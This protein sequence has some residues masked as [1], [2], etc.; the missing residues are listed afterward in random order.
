MADKRISQ[1]IERVDIANNDVLPIVASGATTTNKVTISTIQNWMQDNLDVGV[2]SVGI[3][4]GS[5]GTDVNVTGSPITTSGNIT[6]NIPTASATNRGLLSSA[7]WSTFNAKQPAGNYVTLDTTQTITAHKTFTASGGQPSITI[8]H[9]SG[10][11]H[12]LDITKAGNGEGIRVNKTSGSGNAMSVVGTLE[13]TTLVRTGGTS[14][15]FL[16]A[17]GSVDSSTYVT[18]DTSQAITATKQFTQGLSL[19]SAGGTNQ[20]TVVK[21]IGTIHEGSAGSNIFGFNNSNNIYFGKGLDNGGVIT[22]SNSAVRSYALPDASGTIALT[23]DLGNYVTIGT[24]QTITG[25]KTISNATTTYMDLNS[26]NANGASLNFQRNG[27]NMGHI[28]NSGVLGVG[29]LD[30]LEVRAGSTRALHLKTD[31]GQITLASTGAVT[32]SNLAGTGTRMVVADSNGVLSSLSN[33]VTGTLATGQVAFGTAANTVGGDNGLFWDNTNKRL[34][35]G[36]IIPI[37]RIH[38][39]GNSAE[40]TQYSAERVAS[41]IG[42]S[43]QLLS[44]T[45]IGQIPTLTSSSANIR[46][47]GDA[48]WSSTSSP[49]RVQFETT[50]VGS[51]TVTERWRITSAGILQSNGAQTI[52]TS[53]GNLTLATAAGNGNILLIPNG[54]GNVGVGNNSPDAK[55][56]VSDSANLLQMRIG[57]LTA[58]ISPLIRIQGRNTANTINR[59]ADIKLD[60]DLGIFTLMA[61]ATSGPS[62]NALNIF[63]GGNVGINT[64][65]DSGFRLD[66]NGTARVS[67]AATFSSSVTATNHFSTG[68]STFATS[69]GQVGIGTSSFAGD[70][71]LMVSMNGTTNTQAINVKDRNAAASSS[72]YMVFRKSD[73]TFQG[74]IR[75]AGTDNA[76]YVGGNEYISFGTGGNTERMRITSDAYLR[77]AAGSGGIQFNGDTSAANALDD[78]EE[79]TWTPAFIGTGG[80][81]ATYNSRRGWYT[82]IGRQV[83]IVW[84]VSF[85]KGTI[86]STLGMSGL[87][88]VVLADSAAFYP[89]GTVLL[90]NLLVATNNITFQVSNGSTQGDFIG[91]NGGTTNHTGLLASSLGNGTMMCRGAATYFV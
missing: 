42:S 54:T 58:G 89:Q 3:T 72:T 60:A 13:A 63:T 36:S 45:A 17:D 49:S 47:I 20:L 9:S 14:S 32:L 7:D 55:L 80:G 41:A 2:T 19:G 83:T 79:G 50:S 15:Q 69:S 87:P 1:L 71:V 12:A 90:D 22:W 68:G 78:Y 57:S 65:T 16:K 74:N 43:T 34:G 21:N 81:S 53:T 51:T 8:N 73:D 46:I 66:V 33:P 5:S 88:F 86:I 4:L 52:Q 37:S 61:P 77:M 11:G 75:R 59:Y 29:V 28:G 84:E 35:I 70:E 76:L 30:D 56:V 67:G 18:T 39:S 24:T 91:G 27:V 26:T 25:S 31:G 38:I 40:N 44:L 10:A 62:V 48:T 64:T 82:K 85:Q 23:S 6:I